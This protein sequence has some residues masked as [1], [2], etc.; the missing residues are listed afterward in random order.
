MSDNEFCIIDA[1]SLNPISIKEEPVDEGRYL[2][3]TNYNVDENQNAWKSDQTYN[4]PE[5]SRSEDKYNSRPSKISFG[6]ICEQT[7]N[8]EFSITDVISLKEECNDN[9]LYPSTNAVQ[10]NMSFI[11]SGS[12]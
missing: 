10:N 6:E 3:Y 12:E 1:V 4:F 5:V 11:G 2:N 9:H 7:D 8:C